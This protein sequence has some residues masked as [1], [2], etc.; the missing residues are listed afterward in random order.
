ML[1]VKVLGMYEAEWTPDDH[2]K[3]KTPEIQIF[4]ENVH[5]RYVRPVLSV[6]APFREG[7]L[8]GAVWQVLDKVDGLDVEL[9]ELIG[10]PIPEE[11]EGSLT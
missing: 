1:R 9:I 2:W 6:D 7:G 10:D 8:S 4:M 5:A 3:S 11:S